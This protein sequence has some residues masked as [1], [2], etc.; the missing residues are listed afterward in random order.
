MPND[1]LTR[2][3]QLNGLDDPLYST[4]AKW[5]EGSYCTSGNGTGELSLVRD[6]V[7]TKP[8]L[9]T[10]CRE[11]D[12]QAERF[13][14]YASYRVSRPLS[15]KLLRAIV[16]DLNP[17]GVMSIHC[18][19][20]ASAEV[21]SVVV[22]RSPP[23]AFPQIP[24]GGARWVMTYAEAGRFGA[25]PDEVVKRMFLLI[26]ELESFCCTPTETIFANEARLI[27][28]FVSHPICDG[29]AV[30]AFIAHE[31]PCAIDCSGA[32]PVA[33]F[34]RTNLEHNNFVGRYDPKIGDL[35]RKLMERALRSLGATI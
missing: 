4:D 26:E 9:E 14:L 31:L 20:S 30:V 19:A 16:P 23:N 8:A 6:G 13:R 24:T 11:L 25:Y 32:R 27:R 5:L 18:V 22:G 35:A 28:N 1:R 10:A 29:R 21:E 17:P 2:V 12:D 7:T 15:V 33:R 34:D 3:Y